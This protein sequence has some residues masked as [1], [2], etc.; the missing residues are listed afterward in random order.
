M[1]L[2]IGLGHRAR[3]ALHARETCPCAAGA[4]HENGTGCP[5]LWSGRNVNLLQAALRSSAAKR[6]RAA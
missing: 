3:Q 2:I 1:G 5:D 4:F 6:S